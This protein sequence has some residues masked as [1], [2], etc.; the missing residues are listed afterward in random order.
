MDGINSRVGTSG[1]IT[2]GEGGTGPP[3]RSD[4]PPPETPVLRG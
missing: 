2:E 1:Q 4:A 3:E